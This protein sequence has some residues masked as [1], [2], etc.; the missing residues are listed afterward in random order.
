VSS[1][2][3]GL[4]TASLRWHGLEDSAGWEDGAGEGHLERAVSRQRASRRWARDG[5][6]CESGGGR[7]EVTVESLTVEVCDSR[8]RKTDK[9]AR[10]E[11]GKRVAETRG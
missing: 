7:G 8:R 3:C 6:G 1:R 9:T 10:V 2:R 5:V 11:R 4:K